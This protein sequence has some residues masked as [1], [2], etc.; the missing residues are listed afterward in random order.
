[1]SA[2]TYRNMRL[3]TLDTNI[4]IL[5]NDHTRFCLGNDVQLLLKPVGIAILIPDY[6]FQTRILADPWRPLAGDNARC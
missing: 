6:A 1:M 2:N 3:E 4:E 5:I